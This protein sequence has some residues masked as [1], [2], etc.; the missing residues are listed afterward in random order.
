MLINT[1]CTSHIFFFF[2]LGFCNVYIITYFWMS[3]VF[4]LQ[5]TLSHLIFK[6]QRWFYSQTTQLSFLFLTHTVHPRFIWTW[7]QYT[8]VELP[9]LWSC[10]SPKLLFFTN[11]FKLLYLNEFSNQMASKSLRIHW[12]TSSIT[13]AIKQCFHFFDFN[14]GFPVHV[15]ILSERFFFN[16]IECFLILT[17]SGVF[18]SDIKTI[19]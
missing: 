10:F 15:T 3:S 11:N 7:A 9:Q 6:L 18:A 4:S 13:Y 2:G 1:F 8:L 17:E 14:Y 16:N 5:F 12:R 19:N